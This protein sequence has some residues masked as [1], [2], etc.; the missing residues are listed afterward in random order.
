MEGDTALMLPH[1]ART[2]AFC[3]TPSGPGLQS[4]GQKEAEKG[5][6]S[7]SGQPRLGPFPDPW[8]LPPDKGIVK[9]SA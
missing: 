8:I 3:V 7:W 9:I 4:R 1:L 6:K 5:S 2:P